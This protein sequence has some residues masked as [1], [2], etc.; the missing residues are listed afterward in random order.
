MKIQQFSSG[1]LNKAMF[2]QLVYRRGLNRL[3]LRKNAP[4]S[5]VKEELLGERHNTA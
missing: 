4:H 5:C 3:I 2:G 1:L